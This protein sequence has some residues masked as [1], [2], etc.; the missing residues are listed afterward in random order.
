MTTANTLKEPVF[1]SRAHSWN[2]KPQVIDSCYW[3]EEKQ[4]YCGIYSNETLDEARNRYPDME[5]MEF[6][7]AYA[8]HRAAYISAPKEIDRQRFGDMLDVLPPVNWVRNH[9][10][11]SFKLSERDT[12][13]ITLIC[14]RRGNRFFELHD[15][16]KLTHEEIM[17][18][19]NAAFPL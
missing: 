5:I 18:R 8:L 1:F 15:S 2:G 10:S 16:I 4:A 11:E 9:D 14:V 6:D 3:H 13:D 12:A 17:V 7:D 19:V